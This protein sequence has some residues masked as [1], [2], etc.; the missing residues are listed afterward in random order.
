[1]CDMTVEG[2]SKKIAVDPFDKIYVYAVNGDENVV[3]SFGS[4]GKA[5]KVY[6]STESL[7][8]GNVVKMQ[9][10]FDGKLYF[11]S[12][13]GKVERLDG[14]ITN[15]VT[16]YKKALSVTVEKSENLAGVGNPVSF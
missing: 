9:T 6:S 14:E 1:M 12:D 15:G 2:I 3:Y 16:S 11:L 4:D 5:S 10:D 8:D 7:S 13:N